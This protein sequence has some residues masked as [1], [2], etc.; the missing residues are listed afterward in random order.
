MG[1]VEGMPKGNTEVWVPLS[2]SSSSSFLAPLC[3]MELAPSPGRS[4]RQLMADLPSNLQSIWEEPARVG[5]L[6]VSC[7]SFF[8]VSF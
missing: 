1:G 6:V 2:F 4:P 5:C 8:G 7:L 3:S